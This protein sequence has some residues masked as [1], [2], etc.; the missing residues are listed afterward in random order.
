MKASPAFLQ[1]QTAFDRMKSLFEN[2]YE[3]N[4]IQRSDWY[5]GYRFQQSILRNK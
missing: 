5:K 2:P 1:G 3:V 4:T